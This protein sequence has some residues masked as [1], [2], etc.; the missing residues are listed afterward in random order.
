[1]CYCI[2]ASVPCYTFCREWLQNFYEQGFGPNGKINPNY[3]IAKAISYLKE[4]NQIITICI[5]YAFYFI[6]FFLVPKPI[7]GGNPLKITW[8]GKTFKT[9]GFPHEDYIPYNN[10][11][12]K[13]LFRTL[14]VENILEIYR[15]L[16][17]EMNVVLLSK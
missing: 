13:P 9:L 16:L 12:F 10:I 11:S 15:A 1:M 4:S 3:S 14:S 17:L 7:P 5:L 8:D 2:V 6:L